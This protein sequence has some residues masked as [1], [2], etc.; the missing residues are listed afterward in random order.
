MIY[1]QLCECFYVLNHPHASKV[2][3]DSALRFLQAIQLR[4]EHQVN[5]ILRKYEVKL[6]A[7]KSKV[8]LIIIQD[9]PYRT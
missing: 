6:L 3:H 4:K 8:Y 5:I 9:Y 1:L 7:E 2:M